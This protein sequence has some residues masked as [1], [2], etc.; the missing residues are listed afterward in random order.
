MKK[1]LE[2]AKKLRTN[3]TDAEQ[4]LWLY[5]RAHRFVNVKFKRQKPVGSYIVDFVSMEHR[6]VIEADGG[7][8][9]SKKDEQRDAWLKTQGF[10]VL[11]FWNNEILQQ[12]DAVLEKIRLT[13]ETLSP[14]P[15][16]VNRRGEKM[17]PD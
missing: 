6:L 16:P 1:L 5:L 9:G 14:G 15:S 8:H 13:I 12:T 3:Q 2:L 11:R 7:Q 17:S 10:T 4:K